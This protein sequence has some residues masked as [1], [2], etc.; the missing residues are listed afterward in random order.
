MTSIPTI[1]AEE[2][3]AALHQANSLLIL[4]VREDWEWQQGHIPG[5]DHM[6]MNEVPAHYTRLDPTQPIVV[7]C[8]MGQRSAMVTEY[9]RGRGLPD[10]RNLEGGMDRW[11]HLGYETD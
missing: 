6:P 5:A 4:D 7:V 10:V 3:H 1:T 2:V 8:H 11:Q 9:L